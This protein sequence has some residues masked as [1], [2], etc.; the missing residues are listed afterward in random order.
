M[1]T[2]QQ[3]KI[4]HGKVK[5]GVDFPAYI[6][7]LRK[8]GVIRYKT[9]VSNGSTEFE[10]SNHFKVESESRYPKKSISNTP[11]KELFVTSIKEHQQGKS[12]YATFCNLCAQCGVNHWIVDMSNMT[13]TY[14]D[15]NEAEL[16]RE[17]IPS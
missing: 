11:N 8:L 4:A 2:L 9:H 12:D 3:I 7:E 1:F 13:C 17:Q 10:G 5:S 15:S 14:Y 6:Q 16:L